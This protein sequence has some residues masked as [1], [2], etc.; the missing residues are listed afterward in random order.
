M[1]NKLE[2]PEQAMR[3]LEIPNTALK[4]SAI[5]LGT[6]N[7]GS[8][9]D[10]KASF[11]LL[12]AYLEQGGNFLDSAKVYADWLRGERSRSEK[13]I[14]RWMR[15]R[16][17]RGQVI[18]ATKG[19]HPNLA[20]LQIPRLSPAEIVADLNASLK[21]LQVE[22]IDLYWLHRDDGHRPVED[23]VE[24]LLRQ[25]ALGKIRY[26]GC[27]NWR[28]ARIKAAQAY[29]WRLGC[30][31]F[32]ANQAMW[33]L[34]VVDPQA[35][36]DQTMVV[37]EAELKQVH[38]ETNLTA[39]AYSSQANGWFQ[40]RASGQT[41]GMSAALRKLYASPANEARFRRVEQLASASG[42]SLTELVL[43]YLLA[44][45]FPTFPIVGSQSLGQLQDSLKAGDVQLT[46]EQVKY[47]EQT[48]TP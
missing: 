34:A 1:I 45:P 24:T 4:P 31:G 41:G 5:C 28:S 9:I 13:T 30:P 19:G 37:M 32:V 20:T 3:Y 11:R 12:D 27:S 38:V 36:A 18:L 8:V 33:S 14:G 43:G 25:V 7:L 26:F 6:A 10:Q 16:K 48:E 15:Q 40:R 47:L 29:A 21:N 35:L 17:N 23:I 44:Q 46:L 2:S 42:L 22:C 39:F